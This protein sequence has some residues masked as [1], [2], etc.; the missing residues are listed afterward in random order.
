MMPALINLLVW[1][2]QPASLAYVTA[3]D[4][5]LICAGA[6]RRFEDERGRLSPAAMRDMANRVARACPD[7]AARIRGL[8][9]APPVPV[10]PPPP[11]PTHMP[12]AQQ[13]QPQVIGRPEFALSALAGGGFQLA[14][15]AGQCPAAGIGDSLVVEIQ[16]CAG[17]PSPFAVLRPGFQGYDRNGSRVRSNVQLGVATAGPDRRYGLETLSGR[18]DPRFATGAAY[19]RLALHG[20]GGLREVA[21][22]LCTIQIR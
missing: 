14:A 21:P 6:A 3:E 1:V 7:L 2:A 19:A 15:P 9:P 20:R 18:S 13:C 16:L 11:G 17:R 22:E 4:D 8:I 12:P 10:T 5:P